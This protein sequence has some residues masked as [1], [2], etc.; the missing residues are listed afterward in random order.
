MLVDRTAYDAAGVVVEIAR[1]VFRGD[2]T[3]IVAWT[4]EL[5]E[6]V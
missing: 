2:R 1:D 4:S 6:T 5:R 3:S